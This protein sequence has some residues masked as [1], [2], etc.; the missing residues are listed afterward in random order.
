MQPSSPGPERSPG[1]SRLSGAGIVLG[2]EVSFTA[3]R[4][5]VRDCPLGG[6][7]SDS[8][9]QVVPVSARL[10]EYKQLRAEILHLFTRREQ[11]RRFLYLLSL[12]VVAG[13]FGADMSP[14]QFA[15]VFAVASAL[16]AFLWLDEFRRGEAI[17]RAGAYIA[18]VIESKEPELRWETLIGQ[19]PSPGPLR[20]ILA[21][22]DFPL[23][24]L[25]HGGL[26]VYGLWT[27]GLLAGLA[28]VIFYVLCFMMLVITDHRLLMRGGEIARQRWREVV[29]QSCQDAGEGASSDRADGDSHSL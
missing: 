8:E 29:E 20:R 14:D 13:V 23:M 11:N 24:F 28:F 3:I 6:G 9:G 15:Y 25:V 1:I 21:R 10:E 12:G 26:A 7:I 27:V 19:Y 2:C 22:A 18:V 16:V 5:Q 4:R 17:N